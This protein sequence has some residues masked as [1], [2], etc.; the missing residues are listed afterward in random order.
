MTNFNLN[1]IYNSYNFNYV[2]IFSKKF[3]LDNDISKYIFKFWHI[4]DFLLYCYDN[5][6]IYQSINKFIKRYD[7]FD[8][9]FYMNIKRIDHNDNIYVLTIEKYQNKKIIDF[10]GF[11]SAYFDKI[12]NYCFG[13]HF[14]INADY[15]GKGLCKIMVNFFVKYYIKL[16]RIPVYG[17]VYKSNEA[18][19]KCFCSY[20]F[21]IINQLTKHKDTIVT[22]GFDPIGYLIYKKNPSNEYQITD[23][24]NINFDIKQIYKD[25]N[26][27]YNSLNEKKLIKLDHN[28]DKFII[29]F[30]KLNDFLLYCYDNKFLYDKIFNN[31]KISDNFDIFFHFHIKLLHYNIIY[32]TTI[33][34]YDQY[35]KTNNIIAI[36]TSFIND[37]FKFTYIDNIHIDPSYIND[38]L[39]F[40]LIKYFT[41]C[42]SKLYNYPIYTHNNFDKIILSSFDSNKYILSNNQLSFDSNK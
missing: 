40:K 9:F 7:N 10:V 33:E 6:F 32:I 17:A 37:K 1:N 2:T 42:Y 3:K 38:K 15:R 34:T 11:M 24:I 27:T 35:P 28:N 21:Q 26:N 25:Y 13:E 29:K 36:L 39:S 16:H 31:F 14:L 22:I 4:N 20:H 19:L 5:K 41:K 12:K 23:N 30:W 8:V 18:A